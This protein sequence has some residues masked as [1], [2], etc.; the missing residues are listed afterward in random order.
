MSA[1]GKEILETAA[2]GLIRPDG[3]ECARCGYDLNNGDSYKVLRC[4]ECGFMY[5]GKTFSVRGV[6]AEERINRRHQAIVAPLVPVLLLYTTKIIHAVS[7]VKMVMFLLLSMWLCFFLAR[8]LRIWGDSN[9]REYL[10]LGPEALVWHVRGRSEVLLS[11]DDLDSAHIG[12]WRTKKVVIRYRGSDRRVSIPTAFVSQRDIGRLLE[13]IQRRV[14][15]EGTH[16]AGGHKP[17]PA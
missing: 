3:Y 17:P 14:R 9:R 10:I 12:G 1:N 6:L 15:N 16:H 8:L 5:D 11:W 7:Y 13:E 2:H 4:Q